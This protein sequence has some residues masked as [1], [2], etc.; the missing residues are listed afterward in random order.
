VNGWLLVSVHNL[1]DVPLRL[2]ATKEEALAA[3]PWPVAED[4]PLGTW[5]NSGFIGWKMLEFCGGVPAPYADFYEEE[6]GEA[7]RS[8]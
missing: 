1:E 7:V 3:R 4:N 8:A 2:F 6:D 5:D